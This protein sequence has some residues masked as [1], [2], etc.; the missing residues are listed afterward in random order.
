[1]H[2]PCPVGTAVSKAGEGTHG[3]APPNLEGPVT[4]LE[5]AVTRSTLS[6]SKCDSK[7]F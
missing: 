1:M 4:S 2:F 3:Y 7:L 5:L 6:L